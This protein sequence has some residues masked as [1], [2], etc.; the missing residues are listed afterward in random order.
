MEQAQLQVFIQSVIDY[1]NKMTN[2]PVDVGVPFLKDN[3]KSI[4]LGYT[5]AIGISGEMRGAIYFTADGDFLSELIKIITPNI[6]INEEQ[7]TGMVGELA[8]TISGNAQKTLGNDYHISVPILFMNNRQ[9]DHSSLE[10][11]ASTFVVPLRW[12]GHNA[13]LAVGLEGMKI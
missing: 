11:Q 3:D 9:E 8:N 2:S 13:F 10:I 6:E 1:F 5:G 4:L 7:L 12:N